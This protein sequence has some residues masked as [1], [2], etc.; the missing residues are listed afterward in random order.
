MPSG[1]PN[2]GR[3]WPTNKTIF[4]DHRPSKPR[5]DELDDESAAELLES[6]GDD[7]AR[8]RYAGASRFSHAQVADIPDHRPKGAGMGRIHP[9]DTTP[10]AAGVIHTDFEKGFIKSRDR[11]V[12]RPDRRRIDGRGQGGRQGADG[13]QGLRHGR[14][15]RGRVPVPA[16]S[17]RRRR[18]RS[19]CVDRLKMRQVLTML[20]YAELWFSRGQDLGGTVA[21]DDVVRAE[22]N[23]WHGL[24][25]DEIVSHFHRMVSGQRRT[26]RS[27]RAR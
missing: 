11:L 18:R 1:W 22:L 20:T 5:L 26:R 4:L 15:R 10:K 25:V 8:A 13:G 2:C 9:G 6:I 16:T 24:D 14:R 19:R 7:R 23:T 3:W 27:S 12:R 17:G 21:P